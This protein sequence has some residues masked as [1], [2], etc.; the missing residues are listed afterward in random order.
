MCPCVVCLCVLSRRDP[1]DDCLQSV[2]CCPTQLCESAFPTSTCVTWGHA[3]ACNS[4]WLASVVCRHCCHLPPPSPCVYNGQILHC[5][6]VGLTIR[7]ILTV[8]YNRP[9]LWV[10]GL[11]TTRCSLFLPEFLGCCLFWHH[12]C[13][14][15]YHSQSDS[16]SWRS[17]SRSQFT[18]VPLA[19]VVFLLTSSCTL[20]ASLCCNSS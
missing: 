2:Y 4:T 15:G 19:L 3:L 14:R 9:G 5:M 16:K 12:C 1:S 7:S 10:S 6:P 20:S 11:V 8:V 17:F 18:P 13:C